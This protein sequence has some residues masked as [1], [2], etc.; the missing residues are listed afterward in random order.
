MNL[1]ALNVTSIQHRHINNKT[2][3][4]DLKT[5]DISNR[6]QSKMMRIYRSVDQPTIVTGKSVA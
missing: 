3:T 1:S 2:I 4:Y 5:I 6:L